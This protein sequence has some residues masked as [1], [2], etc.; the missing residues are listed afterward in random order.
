MIQV[1]IQVN[2]IC[3]ISLL[4]LYLILSLYHILSLYLIFLAVLWNCFGSFTTT[5]YILRVFLPVCLTDQRNL[6]VAK[7]NTCKAEVLKTNA[8]INKYPYYEEL[9]A[10][11]YKDK[12]RDNKSNGNQEAATTTSPHYYVLEST[13][14]T[15]SQGDKSNS[16]NKDQS[17]PHYF[18][19]EQVC[20]FL[21][22]GLHIDLC[23][24]RFRNR[25]I[26][27]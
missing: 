2:Q 23:S 4:S 25:L 22:L 27:R 18:V 9:P 7:A 5:L 24:R 15:S 3:L 17:S 10:I 14:Q 16:N 11:K 21:A 26:F 19:L 20:I 8:A 13:Q 6:S 12:K 1:M